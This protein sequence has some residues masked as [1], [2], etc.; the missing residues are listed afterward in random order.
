MNS[1]AVFVVVSILALALLFAIAMANAGDGDSG[2]GAGNSGDAGGG[3][4]LWIND[5]VREHKH[6]VRATYYPNWYIISVADMKPDPGL[7]EKR[8]WPKP[9][10]KKIEPKP[11]E[12]KK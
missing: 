5:Y 10:K 11:A 3:A 7:G 4:Q 8:Q 9:K 6:V 1:R 12:K 2:G